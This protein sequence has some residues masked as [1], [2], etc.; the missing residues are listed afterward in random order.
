M[1]ANLDVST[2]LTSFG[3]MNAENAALFRFPIKKF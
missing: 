3:L 2:H 1:K